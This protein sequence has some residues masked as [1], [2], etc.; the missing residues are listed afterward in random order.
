MKT[1]SIV[2]YAVIGHFNNHFFIFLSTSH[3]DIDECNASVPVCDVNAKCIN[4][5]GSFTC[6]CKTGL[7]GDGLKCS[8]NCESKFSFVCLLRGVVTF[9]E[10]FF[11]DTDQTRFIIK[12]EFTLGLTSKLR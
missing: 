4:T 11:F 1:C 8:G 9:E 10:C 12:K 6:V 3:L 7:S 2:P 5:I